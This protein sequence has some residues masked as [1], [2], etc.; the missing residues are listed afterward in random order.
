MSLSGWKGEEGMFYGPLEGLI[1]ER[2]GKSL[3]PLAVQLLTFEHILTLC[4]NICP[5][6]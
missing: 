5:V 4:V 2:L 6:A 1:S 3:A